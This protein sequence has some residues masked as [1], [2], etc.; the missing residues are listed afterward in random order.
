MGRPSLPFVISRDDKSS[1]LLW[2]VFHHELLGCATVE[3]D[4]EQVERGDHGYSN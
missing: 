2:I 1:L 3:S 4:I